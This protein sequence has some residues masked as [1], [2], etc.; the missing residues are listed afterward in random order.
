VKKLTDWWNNYEDVNEL[1]R[2]LYEKGKLIGPRD[3]L[4]F[5]ETP[6]KW[7]NEWNAMMKEKEPQE[8]EVK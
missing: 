2:W 7:K 4:D 8:E 1:E 3:V 6:W 5:L